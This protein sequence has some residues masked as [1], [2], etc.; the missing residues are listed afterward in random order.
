MTL[1]YKTIAAALQETLVFDYSA[2]IILLYKSVLLYNATPWIRQSI[3]GCIDLP[4]WSMLLIS[5]G[6]SEY[7]A[8]V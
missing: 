4:H 1:Q 6:S 7:V 2:F 3:L 8:H 5:D